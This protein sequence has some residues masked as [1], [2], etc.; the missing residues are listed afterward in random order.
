MSK[1]HPTKYYL[2][3]GL[4]NSRSTDNMFKTKNKDKI[5][6]I[7]ASKKVKPPKEIKKN[8]NLVPDFNKKN[9]KKIINVKS[10]IHI[11][12][13]IYRKKK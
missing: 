9:T 3:S 2:N 8:D 6:F 5:N 7:K 1:N 12:D 13:K 4:P 11:N 10:P